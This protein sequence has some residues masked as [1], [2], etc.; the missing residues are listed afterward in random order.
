M[1]GCVSFFFIMAQSRV[2]TIIGDSNVKRNISKT[3]SRACPAMAGSQ[4]LSCQRLQLLEDV[5]GKIRKESNVCILSCITNLITD[6]DADSMV[7]KRVEPVVEEFSSIL[8]TYCMAFPSTSFLLAPPMYRTAPLWYREGLPEVLTRFSATFRDK[9]DNLYLLPSFPTPEYESD[10]V[11]LTA[12]SGLEFMIHLFDSSIAILDGLAKS[13][14]ERIPETSEAARLLEDRVMVLE[15]DHR[16]LNSVVEFKTAVDAELHDYHENISCESFFTITGCPRFPGLSPKEWQERAKSAV[17]PILKELMGRPVPIEYISNATGQGRDAEIRYKVKLPT[18]QASKE[19]RDTFGSFYASGKDERPKY[20]KKY[21][22]RNLITQGT[23][24]R[25]AI[26]Q[27]LGRRYRDSNQGAKVKVVGY[28]SRPLLRI[29]PPQ[30]ADSRRAQS[31]NF[32]ESV[33]KF[34]TNFNKAELDFILSKVGAKQKG[35]LRALFICINDDMLATHRSQQKSSRAPGTAA[36]AAS[37]E[38]SPAS[39]ESTDQVTEPL[40]TAETAE[41]DSGTPASNRSGK[42]GMKRGA[43]PSSSPPLQPEKSSRV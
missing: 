10:G 7:S 24:I 37:S 5:L 36:A 41:G 1:F 8:S 40:E 11:H 12:Y 6:S 19:V 16:R 43:P 34:P 15:Q 3:N 21:S 30:T 33:K 29:I 28:D 18:V 17:A 22:I 31:F 39:A 9:P 32:I 42:A 35:Q 2:F 13:C 14:D 26:L 38:A 27:V 20:F 4:I 23:R 25:I